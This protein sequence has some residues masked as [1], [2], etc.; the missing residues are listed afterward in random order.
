MMIPTVSVL[1][2]PYPKHLG[3]TYGTNPLS[4][5]LTILHRYGLSILHFPLGTALHTVCL[6]FMTL[7]FL[8][9]A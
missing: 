3:P 9:E 6:H 8:L 5:R 1:A 4:C 2:L 7:P